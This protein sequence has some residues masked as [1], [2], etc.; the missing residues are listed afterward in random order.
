[1]KPNLHKLVREK[2]VAAHF[3]EVDFA[4]ML[5]ISV[6]ALYDLEAYE[7]EWQDLV[8]FYVVRFACRVLN[9][10]LSEFVE[11]KDG[12][13]RIDV[14]VVPGEFVRDC[15]IRAGLSEEDFAEACGYSGAFALAVELN[16]G[17]ILRVFDDTV[18]VCS[19]LDINL[20]DFVTKALLSPI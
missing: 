17:L 6:H 13:I 19:A 12:G 1:M 8:P 15:R 3:S 14:N 2:R 18:A 5:G 4:A 11:T 7:K 16:E 10:D 9:I 20:H